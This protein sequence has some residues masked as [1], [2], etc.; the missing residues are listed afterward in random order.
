MV[1]LSPTHDRLESKEERALGYL[2]EI[3]KKPDIIE[4]DLPV[5]LYEVLFNR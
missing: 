3:K 2:E 1:G 5:E 4:T